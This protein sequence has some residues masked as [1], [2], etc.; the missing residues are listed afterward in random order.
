MIEIVPARPSHVDS[1]A[2]RMREIDQVECLALGMTPKDA[3][4][5]G[6]M[7]ATVVWTALVDGKPEAMFGAA[8]LSTID[9]RGLVWF[10]GTDA[11][12][13]HGKSM[14]R[15]GWRYTQALHDH[16]PILENFVHAHNDMAIRWLARLGYAVGSVE[17][18][19]GFPMR[20]F[21]RCVAQQPLSH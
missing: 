18:Y 13:Y 1:I 3:L 16:F 10:L 4:L 6:L 19:N 15:L 12:D 14:V 11:V 17:V 5:R 9:G 7:G 8:P 2:S 20:R 21:I